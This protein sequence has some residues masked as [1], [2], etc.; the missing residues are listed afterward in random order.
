LKL[1]ENIV[2]GNFL[3]ALGFAVR[4]KS[5][6]TAIPSV[7]NLLQQ[8]PSDKLLG[9]VLLEFP[10]VV[11]L[12]EFKNRKANHTKES[13]KHRTLTIGIKTKKNKH[14][15]EVSRSIHWFI[16]THPE[17]ENFIS[18]I[19]PYLDAYPN[20]G[21]ETCFSFEKFIELTAENAVK[22]KNMFSP[23]RISDY[24][25]FVSRFQ[26]VNTKAILLVIDTSSGN[27][28]N[29]NLTDMIQLRL[30]LDIFIKNQLILDQR[31]DDQ[32]ILKNTTL[33][34]QQNTFRTEHQLSM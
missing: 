27:I 25:W 15:I 30:P 28:V 2:I 10:G 6:S 3:Y 1:Y 7:I 19:V 33:K 34:P 32:R 9:D 13:N 4:S 11:R 17:N 14:H 29:S 20:S 12:I 8:T 24:L 16:E 22:E 18:R 21:K 23:E 5:S 31:I 26:K